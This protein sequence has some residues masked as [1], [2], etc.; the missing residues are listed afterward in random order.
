MIE[1]APPPTIWK[2]TKRKKPANS[3]SKC[4]SAAVQT[5]AQF[6]STLEWVVR[7]P[8][9]DKRSRVGLEMSLA[10]TFSAGVTCAH[11]TPPPRPMKKEES[12]TQW[13][14]CFGRLGAASTIDQR[15]S[16][17]DTIVDD[18]YSTRGIT[19]KKTF[20]DIVLFCDK[21]LHNEHSTSTDCTAVL[22]FCFDPSIVQTV[23]VTT[24]LIWDRANVRE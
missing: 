9:A 20:S 4:V 3:Y 15:Q 5:T 23:L 10:A 1:Q 21:R 19:T 13:E 6:T 11:R 16:R 7:M 24:G 2:G 14:K 22:L 12:N 18:S 8:D 17:H